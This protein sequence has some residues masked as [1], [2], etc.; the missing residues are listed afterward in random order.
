VRGAHRAAEDAPGV[1]FDAA[2][3]VERERAL[4]RFAWSTSLRIA[5]DNARE[6]MPNRLSITSPHGL[7]GIWS[8]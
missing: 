4:K 8:I 2:R 5:S 3:D 1:S 7:A 6:P